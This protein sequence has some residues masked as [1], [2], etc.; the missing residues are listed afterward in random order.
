MGVSVCAHMCTCT[1]TCFVLPQGLPADLEH[2]N[3]AEQSGFRFPLLG[4]QCGEL[5]LREEEMGDGSHGEELTEAWR[6]RQREGSC[7][8]LISKKEG[9]EM[10]RRSR[11]CKTGQESEPVQEG[12][13]QPG[14]AHRKERAET[15]V[16]S[17]GEGREAA[18]KGGGRRHESQGGRSQEMKKLVPRETPNQLCQLLEVSRTPRPRPRRWRSKGCL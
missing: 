11:G 14:R 6:G 2:K 1:K 4:G 5:G 13:R 8:L 16:A 10:K 9:E 17:C 15:G 7:R 18:Q 3:S 12:P